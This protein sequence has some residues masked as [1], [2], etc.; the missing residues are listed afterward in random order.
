MWKMD[1]SIWS[2][3]NLQEAKK[4]KKN[5]DP[6]MKNKAALNYVPSKP[7]KNT[8]WEEK[9]KD[10]KKKNNTLQQPHHELQHNIL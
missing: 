2:L 8:S 1:S 3:N 6:K 5:K 7:K 10:K 9:R 4:A